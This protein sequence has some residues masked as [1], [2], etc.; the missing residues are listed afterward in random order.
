MSLKYKK[1]GRP[2]HHIDVDINGNLIPVHKGKK[3]I[4]RAP[5]VELDGISLEKRVKQLFDPSHAKK[6]ERKV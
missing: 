1:Q 4:Q 5:T 6:L 2:V 3:E